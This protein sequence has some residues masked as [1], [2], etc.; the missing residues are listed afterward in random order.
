MSEDRVPRILVVDDDEQV[1]RVLERTLKQAGFN[2]DLA[3][4]ASEA[5]DRLESQRFTLALC[6][7]RMP[8][9]DGV[10]L[11]EHLA[12]AYPDTAIVMVT[13]EDDPSLADRASALGAYGYVV[14]PF[15]ANEILINVSNAL[16]RRNLEI[17]NRAYRDGLERTVVSRT[18]QLRATLSRLAVAEEATIHR[19]AKALEFRD[20]ETVRHTERMSAY[21][22]ILAARAGLG[23][24]E[25]EVIRIASVLHDVGKIGVPD[26][27]LLKPG[28]FTADDRTI[29]ER[30][31]DLGRQIL[32][33][34][35]E[36]ELLWLASTIAWT[37]HER[38][39]GSGYPRG[40]VG[41]SIPLAGRIAAIADV[42]DA[43]ST[44]RRYRNAMSLDDVEQLMRSSS[45]RFD[46]DLLEL[47]FSG[48][49][50][51]AEVKAKNP[52]LV[53]ITV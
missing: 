15:T 4:D 48:L 26:E 53:T 2:C 5:R 37:H 42:F 17:E 43:V 40:L 6:D 24:D 39:D 45:G 50:E 47:F 23:A 20:V 30:H 51:V 16:R 29:M 49:D 3:R 19:L 14:K 8:G 33:D 7:V 52:E 31:A 13:G 36:E 44:K 9:E 10:S 11:V 32:S 27:V 46:R 22:A 21:S 25:C 34:G 12:H 41:K 35:D 38:F 1:R 28:A 18:K